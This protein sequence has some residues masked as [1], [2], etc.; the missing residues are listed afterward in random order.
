MLNLTSG[1]VQIGQAFLDCIVKQ[2][3]MC[4]LLQVQTNYDRQERN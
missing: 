3:I 4:F 1:L 2:S